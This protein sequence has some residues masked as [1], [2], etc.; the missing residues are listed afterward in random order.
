MLPLLASSLIQRRSSS[1]RCTLSEVH[2]ATTT[3]LQG[4][5][6]FTAVIWSLGQYLIYSFPMSGLQ[7]QLLSVL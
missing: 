2:A 4:N 5:Y 1:A 7:R 6:D 3:M